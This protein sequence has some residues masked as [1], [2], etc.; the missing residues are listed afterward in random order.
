MADEL[1]EHAHHIIN[2]IITTLDINE[3]DMEVL[4]EQ[5][6]ILTD[7][8]KYKFIKKIKFDEDKFGIPGVFDKL[9]NINEEFIKRKI[10]DSV[11]V[12]EF[13]RELARSTVHSLF[14]P[15]D[16]ALLKTFNDIIQ[17]QNKLRE[18]DFGMPPLRSRNK[19]LKYVDNKDAK[20]LY[21]KYKTKYLN[22]KNNLTKN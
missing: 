22:L 7:S 12:R 13:K 10:K 19:Y 2:K 3:D 16:D 6:D 21:I 18:E 9:S 4:M 14:V 1:Q 5:L 17:E 8:N 11:Q 15:N 20:Q